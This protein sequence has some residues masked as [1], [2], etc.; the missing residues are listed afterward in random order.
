M[1]E[2]YR[3]RDTRLD[4]S[5][6]IKISAEEFTER[7]E[8]EARAISA[9]NHPHICTL[10]DIGPNYLVMELVDGVTLADR[11]VDG[12]MPLAE[13]LAVARQVAEAL[14]AAHEK[15]IVHRDL[16]PA[17]VKLTADDNIKVLDFG[18]AKMPDS[19]SRP[20]SDP[21]ISPTMTLAATRA[22]VILGTA[23]Y[24]SPEQARGAAVDKRADIWAFGCLLYELLT[25]KRAFGGETLTDMLAA[26]IRADPDWSALPAHTPAP[27]RRL[28]QR[29]LQKDRKR[30][31]PDIGVARLEIDDALAGAE[32][33]PPPRHPRRRRVRC[34]DGSP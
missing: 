8:R 23:A 32:T 10:H 17:N 30:R 22:G 13:T 5:V 18:L 4:R 7:F 1:G 6:A 9:L 28:L 31:L 24:M 12:P 34:C 14:E 3:A 33:A 21:S 16:K 25:G 29:C 19:G 11:L 20:G 26:V 27:I 2:V 15:G